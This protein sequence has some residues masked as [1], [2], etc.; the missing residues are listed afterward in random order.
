MNSLT[1]ESPHRH[2]ACSSASLNILSVGGAMTVNKPK[3]RR[4][5]VAAVLNQM[6]AM[7]SVE[8]IGS[9]I[10][11]L[12]RLLNAYNVNGSTQLQEIKMAIN[13]THRAPAALQGQSAMVTGSAVGQAQAALGASDTA[14]FLLGMKEQR[15][16]FD[17]N[18]ALA[19]NGQAI[20]S[21]QFNRELAAQDARQAQ[22]NA[23]A[24]LNRQ[25]QLAGQQMR[26]EYDLAAQ[27]QYQYNQYQA[28]SAKSLDEQVFD[29]EA[30]LQQVQ[31]NPEGQRLRNE[32]SGKLRKVREMRPILRPEQY[33]SLMGQWYS[34]Y[35]STNLGAYEQKEPTAQEKVYSGL[36]PLQGQQMVP[37]QPLPP[38]VYRSLKGSRNGVDTWETLTI[39]P[40][41]TATMAERI[42]RDRAPAPDGGIILWNPDKQTYTHFPPAKPEKPEVV[43][44]VDMGKY[45]KEAS[46]ALI[47]EHSAN[48]PNSTE[49]YQPS[50]EAIKDRARELYKM[51]QEL[52]G[53]LGGEYESSQEKEPPPASNEQQA[54][55]EAVSVS[56]LNEVDPLPTGTVAVLPD[57]MPVRSDGPGHQTALSP[58]ESFR[59]GGFDW[60][61]VNE[62]QM[63]RHDIGAVRDLNSG[64]YHLDNAEQAGKLKVGDEF[65]REI[66]PHGASLTSIEASLPPRL[67]TIVPRNQQRDR[68]RRSCLNYWEP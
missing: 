31:L 58:G 18:A 37:G 19:A 26:E 32:L 63:L 68:H 40:V 36:V 20:R 39:P 67:G 66:Q 60:T 17:I 42:E 64:L 24:E 53:E 28:Q 1:F 33:N 30:N 54:N 6:R 46:V 55:A 43:K 41:D 4:P 56:G 14:R 44:P 50:R 47:N 9:A 57:G 16:H 48:N 65:D 8:L 23:N 59:H 49:K 29:A 52:E 3:A 38:G 10:A 27:Q 35:S 11:S 12:Q 2:R 51:Q 5:R 45:I 15:R 62:N 21:Q 34:D 25:A 61:V 13:V 22:Y 7:P